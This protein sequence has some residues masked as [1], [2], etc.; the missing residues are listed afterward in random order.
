M[1]RPSQFTGVVSFSTMLMG[2]GYVGIGMMGYWSASSS[3]APSPLC[4]P[5]ETRPAHAHQSLPVAHQS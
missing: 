5:Q 3:L 2:A 1:Q 4:M